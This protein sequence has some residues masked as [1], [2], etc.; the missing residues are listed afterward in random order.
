MRGSVLTQ[1]LCRCV[2]RYCTSRSSRSGRFQS[3]HGFC[4]H[5]CIAGDGGMV[6]PWLIISRSSGVVVDCID[7]RSARRA[8]GED[9]LGRCC[10]CTMHPRKTVMMYNARI[11]MLADR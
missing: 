6:R 7:R 10:I 4:I 1:W 8:A 2:M 5:C 11:S 9:N 3:K